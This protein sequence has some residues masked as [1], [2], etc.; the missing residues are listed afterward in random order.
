MV[1]VLAM[2]ATAAAGLIVWRKSASPPIDSKPSAAVG[3]VLAD[4]ITRRLGE[5][6]QVVLI[7]QAQDKNAPGVGNE[8]VASFQA[9]L[10]RRKSP[11]L[12]AVVEWLPRPPRSEMAMLGM[13]GQSLFD[14][15]IIKPETVGDLKWARASYS[16]VRG[17]VASEWERSGDQFSLRVTIP[18][19][20]TATVFV[21]G[22]DL[23]RIRESGR[24]VTESEAPTWLRTGASKVG[25]TI[26]SGNYVFTCE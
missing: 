14:R 10:S 3:E 20:A 24:A 9:A 6:G 18:V 16:S 26:G 21:P 19:G 2:V 7:A 1:L 23:T 25:F 8:G 15:I 13:T 11:Q 12:A 5:G 17:K 22:R 4:E